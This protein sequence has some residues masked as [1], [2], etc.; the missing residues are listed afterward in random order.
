MLY[1][2][3]A[4]TMTAIK[5][6]SDIN[7]VAWLHRTIWNSYRE[8]FANV[9]DPSTRLDRTHNSTMPLKIT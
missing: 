5:P 7:K 6:T 3:V 9:T 4:M 1:L 8:R 2:S